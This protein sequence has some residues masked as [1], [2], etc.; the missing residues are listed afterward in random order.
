MRTSFLREGL[1][2]FEMASVAGRVN[3]H[4]ARASCNPGRSENV[5]MYN[6]PDFSYPSLRLVEESMH[7]R[8]RCLARIACALALFTLCGCAAPGR[9]STERPVSVEQSVV[10]AA[11]LSIAQDETAPTAVLGFGQAVA[12]DGDT[13]V[14][15]APGAPADSGVPGSA[16]IFTRSGADWIQQAILSPDDGNADPS[17]G[18]AV[19]LSGGVAVVGAP[20]SNANQGGLFIYQE[21]ASASDWPLQGT[22]LTGPGASQ[23][24]FAVAISDNTIL[25]GAPFAD[26]ST[27]GQSTSIAQA[28]AVHVFEKG[29]SG[30]QESPQVLQDPDANSSEQ[31]GISVAVRGS[32]A[33]VGAAQDGKGGRN[34][35]A[36]YLYTNGPT[37]SGMRFVSQ[38][39]H[40]QDE[41]GISVAL[42]DTG[43]LV[44]AYNAP[45][46]A[47]LTGA[48][49]HW[50]WDGS[51]LTSEQRIVD[52][53]GQDGDSFGASVAL[54]TTTSLVGSPGALLSTGEVFLFDNSD[55]TQNPEIHSGP[56]AT[57]G[58]GNSVA[59][60][61][62]LAFV[63]TNAIGT[64]GSVYVFATS[65][66]LPCTASSDCVNGQC[67]DGVCCNSACTGT[68]VSCIQAN[69]GLPS[70]Q[71]GPVIAGLAPPHNGCPDESSS[72]CGGD[73][74][75]NGAG[76]CTVKPLGAFCGSGPASCPSKGMQD[77][78]DTCDGNGVCV[79]QP[80]AACLPGYVCA[81]GA[82]ARSCTAD[83][84]CD[85]SLGFACNLGLCKI[86][87]GE[88]CQTDDQCGTGH[89]SP[90]RVCCDKEC[91][92]V[93][94]ACTSQNKGSG[95]DG[96]CANVPAGASDPEK[97]CVPGSGQCGAD[98]LCDGTGRCRVY[99]LPTQPCGPTTCADSSVTGQLC[100]GQGNC[101]SN[102]QSCDSY[103][104][105]G[106]ACAT[107]CTS[108]DDC[109]AGSFCDTLGHCGPK[110]AD[111]QSCAAQNECQS[112]C[113]N[114]SSSDL[115]G[116]QSDCLCASL[117]RCSS[118]MRV[119]LDTSGPRDCLTLNCRDGQC[120]TSCASTL[121]DC[122][123]GQN[124]ACNQDNQKCESAASGAR[125][126]CDLAAGADD[127]VTP[128]SL[129][130]LFGF[131]GLY[132]RRRLKNQVPST[133]NGV[134]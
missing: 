24:G 26:Q 71:C 40:S 81:N 53:N 2:R 3:A 67:V 39:L 37:W 19:A 43:V 27:A 113:V 10:A 119:A 82:C 69:T 29:D 112:A 111:G 47:G 79:I 52:A 41:F 115:C 58:F 74:S 12:V 109:V 35:G 11:T 102:T 55:L 114:A 9:S 54:T 116:G 56:D 59:L 97:Q 122:A 33:L 123:P 120:L 93:C 13:C 23:F 5:A 130:I 72:D 128:W 6:L 108:D 60:S 15:G 46:E 68:C 51:A 99:A 7:T 107:T 110:K 90:D 78:A 45:G 100:D 48:A 75:C 44:G 91:D 30:W 57:E 70:G 22:K 20:N 131:T 16:Y 66:G 63:G 96:V 50:Q 89:C 14:I 77:P 98:G 95:V 103:R 73:G 17:F 101:V 92:G 85:V 106:A 88:A 134:S 32:T 124:L 94:E 21:G 8:W 104:C 76:A 65:D 83:T 87:Q 80:P 38:D 126:G 36:A 84:D 4:P 127:R 132:R 18:A 61:G 31:F 42:A 118:D 117:P 1:N 34:A 86:P 62:A 133:R 129:S 125:G 121:D 28:G 49:Y 105:A 64:I 25:V